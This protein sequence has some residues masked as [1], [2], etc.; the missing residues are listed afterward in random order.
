MRKSLI[1]HSTQPLKYV[2]WKRLVASFPVERMTRDPKHILNTYT[3]ISSSSAQRGT[4]TARF[5]PCRV[6]ERILSSEYVEIPP[7][8]ACCECLEDATAN[9][10]KLCISEIEN[11]N[12]R[13]IIIYGRQYCLIYSTSVNMHCTTIWIGYYFHPQIWSMEFRAFRFDLSRH[14]KFIALTLVELNFLINIL[15]NKFNFHALLLCPLEWN[16]TVRFETVRF[17]EQRRLPKCAC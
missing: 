12:R 8:H 9:L 7:Q 2:S 10:M 11:S 6:I 5:H 3:R 17:L 15:R 14:F 1:S 13:Q 4:C 16:F